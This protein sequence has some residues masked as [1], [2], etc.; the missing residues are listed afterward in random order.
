MAAFLPGLGQ[1]LTNSAHTNPSPSAGPSAGAFGQQTSVQQDIH[2]EDVACILTATHPLGTFRAG[3]GT[4][5]GSR[6]HSGSCPP[7][8]HSP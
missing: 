1:Y 6:S 8:F 4:P 2:M 5:S 3:R 7:H